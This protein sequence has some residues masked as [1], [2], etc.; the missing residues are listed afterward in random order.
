HGGLG[1]TEMFAPILPALCKNRRG[2][3]GDLPGHG[4]TADIDR[5]IRFGAMAGDVGAP[6][7]NPRIPKADGK[8]YSSGGGGAGRAPV[9]HPETVRK[10]VV[11]SA[12]FTRNGWY[13]EIL[14]GM[15]QIGAAA[16]EPMK[17]TPMYQVYARTAPRPADW[18][19]LLTKIGDLLR[20]DYDWSQ[21]TAA[22]R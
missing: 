22:V 13:P 19:V 12:A 16:A 6:L 21:D 10:L 14:A 3:A 20:K 18:P 5:P 4:R 2:G 11:V 17:Q 8:G 7:K 9:R 1:S 15:S